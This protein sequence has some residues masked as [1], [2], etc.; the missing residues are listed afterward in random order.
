MDARA[1]YE[2]RFRQLE[3]TCQQ[4]RAEQLRH[5]ERIQKLEARLETVDA[6]LVIANVDALSRIEGRLEEAWEAAGRMLNERLSQAELAE[7]RAVVMRCLV[8]CG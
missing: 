6:R 8:A 4:L 5:G 1:E 2:A 7:V 3:A